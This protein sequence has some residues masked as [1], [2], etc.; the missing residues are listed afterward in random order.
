MKKFGVK[1]HLTYEKYI[2]LINI[3]NE[4]IYVSTWALINVGL[5]NEI[6]ETNKTIHYINIL[7]HLMNIWNVIM[8]VF[9]YV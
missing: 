6:I 3:F 7:I 4:I 8:S 2:P 9:D 1:K 5:G